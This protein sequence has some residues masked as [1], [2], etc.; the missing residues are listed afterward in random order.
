M[1]F[2]LSSILFSSTCSGVSFS[3]N[4]LDIGGRT[5]GTKGGLTFLSTRACQSMSLSQICDLTSFGPLSPS[6]FAGFLYRVL[7]IKSA[8][9]ILHPCG[10]SLFF[11]QICFEKMLSL[12][13]FL[14]FPV[15]GLLPIINSYVMTPR[16][17]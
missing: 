7:L 13:S 5:S 15:Y 6:L 12:I 1:L 4:L 3:I 14:V 8:A 16:A 11:K 10:I 2:L 9:S 17:K